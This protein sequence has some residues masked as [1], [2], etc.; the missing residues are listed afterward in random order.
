MVTHTKNCQKYTFS[1]ITR[2][3]YNLWRWTVNTTKSTRPHVCTFSTTHANCY[4]TTNPNP[5]YLAHKVCSTH[6]ND[7]QIVRNRKQ[8][9]AL[10]ISEKQLRNER[11]INYF[12]MRIP[13]KTALLRIFF[14]E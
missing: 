8:V 12:T 11:Q 6:Q 3:G 7:H 10:F 9:L 4:S 14:A 13:R 5:E 2:V 1:D